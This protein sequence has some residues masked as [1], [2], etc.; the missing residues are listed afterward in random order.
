MSTTASKD[1]ALKAILTAWLVAGTLD[2][3]SA[4]TQFYLTRHIN[5]AP[6]ILRYIA[7]GVFGADAMKGGEGMMLMGLLFHFIIVLGCV[8]VFYGLYPRLRIMR[9]NKWI[10]AVVYGLAVWVV[11]NLVIVPLSLVKR[12]PIQFPAALIAMGILVVAI[13]MPITFI[14][15]AYFNRKK[16]GA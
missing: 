8:L 5:P 4:F 13:G 11:T 1:T 14:I 12:G 3:L 10:T 2:I 6:V 15:G 16:R 9:I 7:S